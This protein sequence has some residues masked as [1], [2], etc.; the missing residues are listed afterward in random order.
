[1]PYIK[2]MQKYLLRQQIETVKLCPTH[3]PFENEAG[4]FEND[5]LM[6]KQIIDEKLKTVK[7]KGANWD[8]TV[9]PTMAAI[10]KNEVPESCTPRRNCVS[11]LKAAILYLHLVM[12]PT[13]RS[14]LCSA[15]VTGDPKHTWAWPLH[16]YKQF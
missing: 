11:K 13:R 16:R 6:N 9:E 3:I 10:P 12:H 4:D 8:V 7:F 5:Y 14:Y 2:R 1:M 15:G